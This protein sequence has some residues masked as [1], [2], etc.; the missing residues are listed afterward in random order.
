[1]NQ[2]LDLLSDHTLNLV[3][4]VVFLVLI[5][6]FRYL[7]LRTVIPRLADAEIAYRSRKLSFYIAAGLLLLTLG[8]IWTR[9]L[10]NVGSFI[11]LLS[12]GIAIALSDV[13]KNM[14]GWVLILFRRPFKVGDRIEVGP[15]AG[16]VIDIGVFRFSLME[17]RNWVDADQTTGRI[18]H[19]PNGIVFAEPLANYNEGFPFIWLEV[20]VTVTFESDWEQTRAMVEDHQTLRSGPRTSI[21]DRSQAPVLQPLP[22]PRTGGVRESNR[23]RGHRNRASA[24]T[25]PRPPTDHV[26][27]MARPT[28]RHQHHTVSRT[29]LPHHPVLPSRPR[30]TRPTNAG[31]PRMSGP[32]PKGQNRTRHHAQPA[33][34]D[35]LRWTLRWYPGIPGSGYLNWCVLTR[36]TVRGE[37]PGDPVFRDLR[38]LAF[39]G[40]RASYMTF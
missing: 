18:L 1:M 4:S 30:K 6:A 23:L 14:A 29:R 19:I 33:E 26:Q 39:L 40:Q 36:R 38:R 11:G 5:F 35:P 16:D 10:A 2:F 28:P 3:L 25:T 12:A 34:V 37:A 24:G 17:I 21:N 15:N 32:C 27:N 31:P 22:E 8:W 9:Q 13:L 20:P 7:I